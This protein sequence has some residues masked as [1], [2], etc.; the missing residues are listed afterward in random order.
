[1]HHPFLARFCIDS[2]HGYAA[3]RPKRNRNRA[4]KEASRIPRRSDEPLPRVAAWGTRPGRLLR[5][6]HVV[7]WLFLRL[8]GGS[9]PPVPL[10]PQLALAGRWLLRTASHQ[11]GRPSR[12]TRATAKGRFANANTSLSLGLLFPSKHVNALHSRAN[13]VPPPSEHFWLVAG[14]GRGNSFQGLLT[15]LLPL[16]AAAIAA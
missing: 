3:R 11:S 8:R 15:A 1:M 4:T 16:L 7:P 14:P 10:P 13:R 12:V 9:A 2:C 6:S 5:K